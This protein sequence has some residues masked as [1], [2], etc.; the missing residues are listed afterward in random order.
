MGLGTAVELPISPYELVLAQTVDEA[1]LFTWWRETRGEPGNRWARLLPA[2]LGVQLYDAGIRSLGRIRTALL[3]GSE[4]PFDP[5]AYQAL[6]ELVGDGGFE[7]PFSR[8]L[9]NAALQWELWPV[10]FRQQ[11]C[12]RYGF[13]P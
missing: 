3:D 9:V 4:G 6:Q 5:P 8:R 10:T 2:D 11:L 12:G 13:Q 1:E 7:P